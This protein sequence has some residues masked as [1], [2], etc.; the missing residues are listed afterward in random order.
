MKMTSDTFPVWNHGLLPA[1]A[2]FR[3]LPTQI[4]IYNVQHLT[5]S[6]GIFTLLTSAFFERM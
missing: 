2:R 3:P 5:T 6:S 1:S 4:R